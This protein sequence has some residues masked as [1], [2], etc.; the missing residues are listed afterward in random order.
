MGA[1]GGRARR[2]RWWIGAVVASTA[3]VVAVSIGVLTRT[4]PPGSAP[5][6]AAARDR[7]M[8]DVRARLP[9]SSNPSISIENA[10][11][12]PLDP[13]AKDL[14][15]LML[16]EP[17]KGVDR[18]RITVWAVTGVVRTVTESGSTMRGPF[19]CR[20]YTVDGTTVDTLVLLDHGH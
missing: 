6:E 7:C 4:A 11:T 15:P 13:D 5:S 20:A 2:R 3:V 9:E 14:F 12:D 17:L 16:D 1:Q 19:E 10:V 8:I 18:S